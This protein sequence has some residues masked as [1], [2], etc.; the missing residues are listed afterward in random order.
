M[1]TTLCLQTFLISA[2]SYPTP[3][4][5]HLFGLSAAVGKAGAAIGTEVFTPIQTA[6]GK[7]S[8]QREFGKISINIKQGDDLKGQQGVFLIASAFSVVGGLVAFFF[9]PNV[10]DNLLSYQ[11][12]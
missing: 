8:G 4:R 12:D 10:S 6:I 5:G 1:L 9:V 3:L 7:V 2:E 11:P